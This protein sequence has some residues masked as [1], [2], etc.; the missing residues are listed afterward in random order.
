MYTKTNGIV[1]TGTGAA[2]QE[3]PF[4]FDAL[5]PTQDTPAKDLVDWYCETYTAARV[6]KILSKKNETDAG[7]NA[8]ASKRVNKG[9]RIIVSMAY[10]M[11]EMM[12]ELMVKKQAGRV[13]M[14]AWLLDDVWPLCKDD[15]TYRL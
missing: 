6:C 13:A 1:T 12:D 14:E 4:A 5:I 10:A 8:R 9:E 7:N 2:K 15:Q 3:I 11:D